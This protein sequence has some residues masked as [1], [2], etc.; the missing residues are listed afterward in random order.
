MKRAT[1]WAICLTVVMVLFVL[2]SNFIPRARMGSKQPKISV[3]QAVSSVGYRSPAGRHKI[4]VSDK[5]L[6][7]SLKAQGGRVIADYDSF[8]LLEASEAIVD[9]LSKNQDA[10]IVDDNNV[11]LLNSGS[12]DTTTPEAQAMRSA[13]SGGGGKQMRLVQFPG[14]IRPDWYQALGDTG[15]RIVT[16]IPN[17]AYLV[18]GEPSALLSVQALGR[19][20]IQWDAPYS[21]VH[22]LSRGIRRS[23]ATGASAKDKDAGLQKGQVAPTSKGNELF[24][25]QLVADSK[26]NAST[27]ALID[28]L[29]LAPIVR[30]ARVMN[31]VNIVVALPES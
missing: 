10:E 25:I 5:K 27:L 9:S 31:Y 29:K 14:P 18:Y 1:S 23:K 21:S 7:E 28:G 30:Q 16:Y 20:I 8:V 26:E 17:N 12:I 2:S 24:A 22:R 13:A 6:V 3:P 15:V 11:V 4:S 19:S